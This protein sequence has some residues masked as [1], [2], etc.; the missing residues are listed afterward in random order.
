MNREFI[1]TH[2]QLQK[3]DEII[4]PGVES[5]ATQPYEHFNYPEM[6]NFPILDFWQS[7]PEDISFPQEI[8]VDGNMWGHD[9]PIL[10]QPEL[11]IAFSNNDP[12]FQHYTIVSDNQKTVL[13]SERIIVHDGLRKGGRPQSSIEQDPEVVWATLKELILSRLDRVE[14]PRKKKLPRMDVVRTKVMRAIFK[15]PIDVTT[16]TSPIIVRITDYKSPHIEKF[17][18][19]FRVI[20]EGVWGLL[21]DDSIVLGAPSDRDFVEFCALAFPPPKVLAIAE[22]HNLYES[23]DR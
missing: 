14:P 16:L 4:S 23:A 8:F 18:Q 1:A 7:F 12:Q 21:Q 5:Q 17:E 19:A 10:A 6:F 15:L 9:F 2:T 13:N 3:D 22:R 11:P 20:F